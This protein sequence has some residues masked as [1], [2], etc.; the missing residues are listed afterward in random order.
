M[1][2]NFRSPGPRPKIE[3]VRELTGL[4]L[5]LLDGASGETR[6]RGCSRGPGVA[7]VAKL[8]PGVILLGPGAF[9]SRDPGRLQEIGEGLL[10]FSI[11]VSGRASTGPSAF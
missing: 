7:V 11:E 1:P 10:R 8:W 9:V 3:R 5:E 2:I 6:D 4:V